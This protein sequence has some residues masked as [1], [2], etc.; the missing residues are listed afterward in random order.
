MIT[1]I[2]AEWVARA[3]EALAVTCGGERVTYAELDARAN[4]LA[5]ALLAQGIGAG[6]RVGVC[7]P[8]GTE[9]VVALL[10][11][12]KAGAAAVPLDPEYPRERLEFMVHDAG[13]AVVL[14][15]P[16]TEALMRQAGAPAL[17]AVADAIGQPETAPVVA[18][19]P[20]SPAYV[21]YTSGSTGR[22]K[23][24][25]LPHEGFVRVVR[26]PHFDIRASDVVSQ[27]S[28][29]SF[30]AGALE[31]WNALLNGAVLAVSVERMLSVGE[32]G[33]FVR[34]HGV[35][36]LW[37]TA[38]LFH[39]VVDADVRVFDGVRVVM[40]G[41]DALSPRHCRKVLAEVP[42]VRLVNVYGPTEVSIAASSHVIEGPVLLGG[43]VPDTRLWV[44][45]G[46]LEPVGVGVEGELYVSGVGLAHGYGGRAGLTAGRF[47]AAPGGCGER[48][49]RTGDVVRWTA[50]G[51]LEFVRRADDQVKVRGFRVEL[52]EVEEALAA[53]RDVSQA[54]AVVRTDARGI[55]RLV[56]YVVGNGV[57]SRQ[58]AEFLG[59]SLPAYMIPT[60]FVVV[61]GLPLTANGKVDRRALPEPDLS[62]LSEAEYVAPRTPV[63][64]AVVGVFAEVL[65]V[66]RVGVRD[67]FFRMGGDSIRAVQAVSRLRRV[68]LEVPVRELFDHP[69]AETLAVVVAT[70]ASSSA[71]APAPVARRTEFPVSFPLSF[72]QARMWFAAEVDPEGT[73]HNT[74]GA[75][76]IQGPLDVAALEAALQVLVVRHE[77]LRTTFDTV[78]GRG[79][80]IIHPPAQVALPV[81]EATAEEAA[82]VL[83]TELET[84]FDLR[85][86]PLLRPT[87]L[88]TAPDEHLLV[89]SMHHIVTDGWSVNVLARELSALYA[90]EFL[91]ELPVQYADY[92]VRQRETLTPQVLD[93]NLAYW[94]SQLAGAPVLDLP[95][96]RPR[97]A[98]R[99]RAGSTYDVDLPAELFDRLAEVCRARGATLF[100]GLTAAVQLM[101]ARTTGEQD[102][103]LGTATIGRDRPEV[104]DVL[105]FFVNT[106]ALRT[107]IDESVTGAELLAAVRGT[108][109]D[110]F[111]H[112]EVPFDRV[113]DAVV[114]ERDPSRTPLVQAMMVLQTRPWQAD[115]VRGLRVEAADLPRQDA[116]FELTLEFWEQADGMRLS[117]NYNT[118]LFDAA[119]VHGMARH[120]E[121]VLAALA[122]APELPLSRI[123]RLTGPERALVLRDWA[124]GADTPAGAVLTDVF[125]E[126]AARAPEAVALVHG[127]ER[128]TYGD[129]DARTDRLAHALRAHGVGPE[130]RVGVCLPRGTEPIVALLAV[131]KAGGV[132]VPLDTNY[133]AERLAYMVQDSGVE[134]LLADASTVA[135]VPGTDVPVTLLGELE[136]F[137]AAR[138][139]PA[140][141]PPQAALT[142]QSGAYV[143]YTSGS[144]GRPKGIVLP[145]AGVLRVVRDPRL[146]TTAADAVAQ[147]ATLSFDASALEIW[148][149]FANGAALVV[150]TAG[151]LSVEELGALLHGQGVTVA[152][153]TAGLFH[154]V[155]DTDVT[156]LD[157][158]RLLMA[159]GDALAP[160]HCRTVLERLPHVRLLN[161]YGPTETTIFTAVHPVEAASVGAFVPIGAPL[162]RTGAYVLDDWL[163][164]VPAGTAGELYVT[165]EGV[166][167]G[168]VG[169]PGLTAERFVAS[170]FG[171]PGER[172]YR[173]GDVVRWLRD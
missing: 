99:T 89:L 110:A 26:D 66:E 92:T 172:M 138:F 94:R 78:D 84:P 23:G 107:R 87:L 91:P 100:M 142:P 64:E 1:E 120:L 16:T 20:Q 29:L 54:V 123:P 30:D 22:P 67:D 97:P 124:R 24:V 60:A 164:P 146:G 79:V 44:L 126:Q 5:H 8:R 70:V 163:R 62:G 130:T 125:A 25:V 57:Q 147:I 17:V 85:T 12:L 41:G 168:Y 37:L 103:V 72:A 73:E 40:S 65:G 158:L 160:H 104:E 136:E 121:E 51:V 80:Q 145:H 98:V 149:A 81:R 162:G 55:K 101:L 52:G 106:L 45:D 151:V 10:G 59:A 118:D 82:A 28:T 154:E 61:D 71:P 53:H 15:A 21:F 35:S 112:A 102:V 7:L 31:V 161:G 129:L 38:G 42:G 153:L 131:L 95:T 32:L 63:E 68:G 173:T 137:A 105:G 166:A 43:P 155:V 167:R 19:F 50:D 4:R 6:D 49:Y 159:G 3:P 88:R 127:D 86:G 114:T 132:F 75:V 69:T 108:V 9:P 122:G 150:S 14:T 46:C 139:L 96:D 33:A 77:S 119:T 11:V 171:G 56:A 90:G 144:T 113:V 148:S 76:R 141:G 135:A 156:V 34:A 48:M 152:W 116:Q 47:V 169:Q 93:E 133:P 115:N 140:Q 134:L 128:T 109:L 170:P 111:A 58:L 39:E 2:F 165:G 13:L 27:L 157:G 143:F 83:R 18:V 74:G 36:V 117:L